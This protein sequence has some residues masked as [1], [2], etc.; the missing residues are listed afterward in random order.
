[1]KR[2]ARTLEMSLAA[3]S[4]SANAAIGEA[5]RSQ[6][7]GSRSGLEGVATNLLNN[8]AE[9]HYDLASSTLDGLSR[10]LGRVSYIGTGSFASVYRQGDEVVKVYRHTTQLSDN[11]RTTYMESRQAICDTLCDH[12]GTIATAQT[13]SSEQHPL[14]T[15]PVVV[16]RQPF[17]KGRPLDLFK[18]NSLELQN[19]AIEA[20]CERQPHGQDQLAQLVDATFDCDDTAGLVPD[21]NGVD[22][23]RLSGLSESLRLIDSE[24][25]C[26]TEHPGVHDHILRQAEVLGV[27]L[28]AA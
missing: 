2:V 4:P 1:M 3:Y 24:P 25:I 18:L 15:Y 14:G 19:A 20:Y 7:Q 26:K 6:I 22:N 28:D 17:V 27:F 9:H 10:L 21:L 13:F 8:F 12:L 11:E 16:G 5:R 23:F